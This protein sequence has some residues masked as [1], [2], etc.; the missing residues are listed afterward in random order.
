MFFAAFEPV[1]CRV[2]DP[3][4]CGAIDPVF[5]GAD[6]QVSCGV[7]DQCFV[8]CLTKCLAI[9]LIQCHVMWFWFAVE[10]EWD[11]MSSD[12]IDYEQ[13]PAYSDAIDEE[14]NPRS[15]DAVEEQSSCVENVLRWY[16]SKCIVV[17]SILCLEVRLTQSFM[18]RLNWHENNLFKF[19]IFVVV[20]QR[21]STKALLVS[22]FNSLFS[23]ILHWIPDFDF[24]W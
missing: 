24:D 15:S 10:D 22:C 5:C 21:L 2:I 14:Q 17:Q 11:L 16:P 19:P 12:P 23:S 8:E 3:W 18:K 7:I 20:R 1:C 6:G 9:W 13:E 4:S